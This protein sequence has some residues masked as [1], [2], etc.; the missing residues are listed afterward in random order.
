MSYADLC[1]EAAWQKR[2]EDLEQQLSATRLACQDW[3]EAHTTLKHTLTRKLDGCARAWAKDLE[4]L[5]K[6]QS[7][8]VEARAALR[9]CP[10]GLVLHYSQQPLMMRWQEKH[11]ATI[12]AAS[13][14]R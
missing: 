14:A 6:C 9:E 8:L 13:E 1:N 10:R 4:E 11:A 12:K 3:R 2:V 5:A 7:G